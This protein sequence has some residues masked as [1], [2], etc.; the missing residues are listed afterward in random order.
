[1]IALGRNHPGRLWRRFNQ[2]RH[3]HVSDRLYYGSYE[4]KQTF[5]LTYAKKLFQRINFLDIL[6]NVNNRSLISV[7]MFGKILDIALLTFIFRLFS[8]MVNA[9]PPPLK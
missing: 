6:P 9:P 4:S 1:M 7:Q 2:N 8:F 3:T 5:S